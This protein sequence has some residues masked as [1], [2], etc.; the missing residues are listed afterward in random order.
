L[1]GKRSSSMPLVHPVRQRRSGCGGGTM[2]V[3]VLAL[4]AGAFLF[5]RSG[6]GLPFSWPSVSKVLA[7]SQKTLTNVQASI[8]THQSSFAYQSLPLPKTTHANYV[9]LAQKDA[10]AVGFSSTV[11][12][13]QINQES[14]FNPDAIGADGEIGIA[15]FMPATARSLGV[16]AH[17]P[18]A[19][20]SGAARLMASYLHTFNG[21]YE[22]ALAAYNA[23]AVRVQQAIANEGTNWKQAIPLSTQHY[24]AAILNE[25]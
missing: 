8:S 1:S 16:N 21:D 10:T 6:T 15:Q 14:G 13:R 5:G 7:S 22:K 24:I 4:L 9:A 23:G 20:L 17:D 2:A 11:F 25:G 12:V 19:A 18:V 3:L